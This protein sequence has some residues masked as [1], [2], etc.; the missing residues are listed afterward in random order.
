MKDKH[1][2]P[3]KNEAHLW[4]MAFRPEDL[5]YLLPEEKERYLRIQNEEVQSGFVI[6]QGGL[7]RVLA[8]YRGCAP[9]EVSLLRGTYGKP[10]VAGG[11]EFNLSHTVGKTFLLVAHDEV[12]LDVESAH[13]C[14][15][16]EDIAGKFFFPEERALFEGLST[17]AKNSL[18][19]RLWVCKEAMVKLSGE[20]IYHGLRHA[21]VIMTE[22]GP[23][24]EYRGGSVHLQEFTPAEGFLA[25]AA[26][27]E[28]LEVKCF[29]QG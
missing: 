8:S 13:R 20:G 18:L 19:L 24:G 6:S 23:E 14:T 21:R 12:G 3:W 9:G 2:L 26:S 1:T 15:M 16:A 4:E 17:E 29:L 5:D 25:A 22:D 11:P 10:S 27:W 7:R 28:K